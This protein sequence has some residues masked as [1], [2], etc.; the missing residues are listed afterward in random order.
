MRRSYYRKPLTPEE[1][2]RAEAVEARKLADGKRDEFRAGALCIATPVSAITYCILTGA[3]SLIMGA[4]LLFGIAYFVGVNVA[5]A[6]LASRSIIIPILA[7]AIITFIIQQSFVSTTTFTWQ[8]RV[9][10]VAADGWVSSATGSGATSHHG[11]VDHWLTI[12][13]SRALS[14]QERWER[15][16]DRFWYLLPFFGISIS[17][18]AEHFTLGRRKYETLSQ[19]A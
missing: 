4:L 7:L 12:P 6:Y 16:L 10:A 1:Q 8:E 13:H 3:W 15:V 18:I 5:G 19:T 14:F 9:G 17:L 11:G 2:K